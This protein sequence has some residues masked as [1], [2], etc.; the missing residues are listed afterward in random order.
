M[1][2]K[3]EVFSAIAEAYPEIKEPVDQQESRRGLE[4]YWSFFDTLCPSPDVKTLSEDLSSCHRWREECGGEIW[5]NVNSTI[6]HYGASTM[7]G[8][9]QDQLAKGWLD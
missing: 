7:R 2:L 4:A 9:L 8:K 6:N 1:L 5:C 3:R